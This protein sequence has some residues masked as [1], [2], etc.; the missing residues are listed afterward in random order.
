MLRIYGIGEEA[1]PWS[2]GEMH[3]QMNWFCRSRIS[4]D[5]SC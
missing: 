1:A 4:H 5:S 2:E 3:S